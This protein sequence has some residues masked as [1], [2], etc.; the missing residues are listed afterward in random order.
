MF[1]GFV[2][3][4]ARVNTL[5]CIF[6]KPAC[7]SPVASPDDHMAQ[8]VATLRSGYGRHV[9]EPEWETFLA[10]LRAASPKFGEMWARQQVAA[11]G[12]MRKVFQ[13]AAVGE[14]R[15][16]T[17]SLVVG[18]SPDNRIVIY[19]ADDEESRQRFAWLRAH[20]DAR[21]TRH[22][23]RPTVDAADP[24]LCQPDRVSDSVVD[25]TAR[26]TYDA[27]V[28]GP[29]LPAAPLALLAEWYA[30]AARRRPDRRARRDGRRDRRRRRAARTR[31]PC[32]SRGWT[33]A[34][35]S[36]TRTSARPRRSS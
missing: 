23:H 16:T 13:H 31:G 19:R 20:P 21:P 32:C 22:D 25:P 4:T 18:G 1:A 2:T 3:E 30:A 28:L 17:T 33:P 7:C 6:T 9:G 24:R 27:E 14:I 34:G 5:W 29:D 11:P 10:D 36:S 35:W 12:P 8:M 26:L 15:A